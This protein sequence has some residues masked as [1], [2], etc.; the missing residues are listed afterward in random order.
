MPPSLHLFSQGVSTSQLS[1]GTTTIPP[2][3]EG[4]LH[5]K[6]GIAGLGD[7]ERRQGRVGRTRVVLVLS[8]LQLHQV[9]A[10]PQDLHGVLHGTVVQADIVDGQQLVPWLEGASPV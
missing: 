2:R 4:A 10:L 7:L 9:L 1:G 3:P 5:G 8:D 6:R